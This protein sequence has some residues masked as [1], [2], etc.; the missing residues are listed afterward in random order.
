MNR[1]KTATLVLLCSAAFAGC[2]PMNDPKVRELANRGVVKAE[3]TT[4]EQAL[5]EYAMANENRYP[6]TLEVLM[7]PNQDGY[8]Y[9]K[10]AELPIDPWGGEY[11]YQPPTPE[12]PVPRITCYGRDGVPGGEGPDADVTNLD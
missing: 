6:D 10:Q 8:L 4:L 7:T 5:M 3:I 1:S 11:V 9:I 12:D 2:D